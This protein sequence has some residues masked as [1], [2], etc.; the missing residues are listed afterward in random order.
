MTCTTVGK[1]TKIYKN[2]VGKPQ[3][4]RLLVEIWMKIKK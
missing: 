4:K 2:L 1:T 3:G